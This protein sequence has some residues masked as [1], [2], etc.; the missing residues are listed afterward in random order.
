MKNLLRRAPRN[1]EGRMAVLDHLRELR[2]RLIIAALIV[3]LGAVL[4]WYLYPHTLSFLKGPYC[5]VPAKYRF[6][7]NVTDP[8]QCSL[9]Y[10]GVLDGFTTRLKVAVISGAVFTAPIWLYQIWAFVTPGL[11][12]NERKYT[13]V[14]IL[15]STLLFVAGMTLA[16]LVLSRGL[17]VV[18][19]AGGA[20][21]VAFLTVTGYLSFVILLL[22]VFGLAFELPLL[23]IMA[24]LAGVLPAKLL[25]KSQ[26]LAIF[27][28]FLF[29]AVATPSTDPF[30][31]CAMAVPM[32]LL[33][34]GAV[35]FASVHDK[36][37]AARKAA[38]A[39]AGPSTPPLDDLIPSKV[40][41]IP[42]ALNGPRWGDST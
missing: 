36:R 21:T 11:K 6:S 8:K 32:C 26:R 18:V 22:T 17:R 14:F 23:V 7:G 3:A 42:T 2:R 27:L 4:G 35:V 19:E 20:G 39:A 16:Y 41:P 5:S 40:D 31:M 37:K 29:A 1:P 9:I 30:T 25:R 34:E 24:N 33:F 28:I 12:R 13:V 10:T 38:E 15:A